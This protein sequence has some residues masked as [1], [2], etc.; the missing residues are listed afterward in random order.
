MIPSPGETEMSFWTEDS[1][2]GIRDNVGD[3][4]DPFHRLVLLNDEEHTYQFV[5]DL[6]VRSFGASQMEACEKAIEINRDGKASVFIGPFDAAQHLRDIVVAAG[7]DP[8]LPDST[9]PLQVVIERI[10]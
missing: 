2:L 4:H 7:A 1:R 8:T 3:A 5:V 9:G 10:D 6:L